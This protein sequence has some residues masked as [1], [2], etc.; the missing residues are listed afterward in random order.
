MNYRSKISFIILSIIM[1]LTLALTGC[2]N[3]NASS[4]SNNTKTSASVESLNSDD[5]FTD[6]D[7][8]IGYDESTA[9]T[10][11]LADGKS[12]SSDSKSVTIQ[13]N[14]ITINSE[15]TY[16]LQGTLKEGQVVVDT[17]KS[18]KVQ[19]VLKGVNITCSSS[20]AIYVKQADKVFITLATDTDNVLAT[21][22]EFINIDDNNIDAT[23]FS[24]DDLTLNGKGTLTIT[25]AAGHGIVSKDDLVL[26]GGVY[27]IT[28]AKHG[29][30][31]KDSVRIADGEYTIV[32]GKDAIHGENK[33]DESKGFVYIADGTFNL[34]SDGDGISAATTL[35]IETA[36]VTVKAGGGA[37]SARKQTSG[38]GPMGNNTNTSNSSDSDTSTK[39]IKAGGD[40]LI[41]GGTFTIN[42]A[43]DSVHS[44]ANI[45]INNGTFT[46]TTGDDGVHA[47][48]NLSIKDGEITITESYE[49]LEGQTIDIAGGNITLKADDD[50]INAAGGND[51]S[52]MFN[53]N[54]MQNDSFA[55]NSSCYI[56]ISGGTLKID[57]AGDGIDSNGD[58]TVS[59]GEIYVD[60]PT[61][62]ADG[63]LDYDGEAVITG[64]VVVAVGASGMAENFG[65][66]STQG[67][68]LV[69]LQSGNSGEVILK[70]DA[71]N[72]LVSYTPSKS[73][74]SVVVSCPGIETGKTYTLTAGGTDT[75]VEMTSLIYG[76]GMGI[77]GPMGGGNM[78]GNMGNGR[79][80]GGRPG[81][82]QGSDGE[83]PAM[84]DSSQG[85]PGDGD[86]NGER[87]DGMPEM[88]NDSNNEGFEGGGR[89][90]RPDNGQGFPGG[91]GGD[92]GTSD[93]QNNGN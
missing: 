2:S 15:G 23:I 30:S 77:G 20:A 59:G 16:I 24:K 19:L 38:F 34:T 32:S 3:Q 57:A 47:D 86:M 50:G 48:E 41:N 68:I 61:S 1:V 43:D 26:T 52:G 80:G 74:N 18:E 72:V 75:T 78:G 73:Y 28:S 4:T 46:L 40:M 63:A 92:W 84:P 58:L 8:E 70:D 11:T 65:E 13:D 62:S 81:D 10:I 51:Q 27:N 21:T 82:N 90:G 64:G 71:G 67:S 54:G 91:R 56:N 79:M 49:G 22:G 42:S 6:R 5:M 14:Q 44:N 66:N 37:E 17:S 25:C 53:R 45:V 87:P 69:N 55:S 9:V 85:F 7:K 39:G 36:H 76:S 93:D 88:P 60:G 31:G 83:M 33:D 35:Q 89:G 29:L 12:T